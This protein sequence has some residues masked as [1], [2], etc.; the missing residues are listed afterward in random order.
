M[1]RRL[2]ARFGDAGHGFILIA[3][4]WEWY[5]HNDVLPRLRRRVEGEPPRRARRA[6]R[7]VRPRRRV[8]SRATAAASRGSATATQ[9]DFG[10]KRLALRR[11]LPGATGR[12]R[13]RDRRAR[14]PP[15]RFSTRGDAK[16]SRVHS[17]HVPRRR[18]EDHASA[19]WAAA[20]CA[21]SAWRSSATSRAS[22]TTRSVRTRAMAVYWQ[23]Q[24]RA[25]WK[26]QLALR[27]PALIVFQYGTNESDLWR[28]DRERVRGGARGA[29][30]RAAGRVGRGVDP[31]RRA[32]RPRGAEGR[33][34]ARPSRVIL[35]SRRA[36]SGAS[37]SP[38]A[39]RSGT[40]SRRWAARARWR[41][42]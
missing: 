4:P 23:R 10:R 37:R 41:A 19:R 21:S 18:G 15:E 17:V 26:D 25:H 33:S 31:R 9:G 40:R 12:R 39:R 22:S 1:R 20:P 2:Q 6:R 36:S 16:V 8:A 35:E 24:D 42:G 28:L 7:H 13:R 38:T 30:R 3:N 34:H 11:L 32:A 27:D 14:R 29:H 5:F